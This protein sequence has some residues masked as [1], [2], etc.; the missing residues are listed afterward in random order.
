[1]AYS[2]KLFGIF[3]RLHTATEFEGNGVGLATVARL[4]RR[5][6]GRGLG[7]R[8]S[9]RW[10]QCLLHS[11]KASGSTGGLTMRAKRIL[12]IEDDPDDETLIM[13]ELA[14]NNVA[15]EIAVARD[16]VEA[17]DYLFCSGPYADRDP[18]RNA[19]FD[20]TGSEASQDRR[21]GGF[22]PDT[23]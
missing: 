15:N 18:E 17:L 5:H 13:R 19:D 2:D 14:R 6:G 4:V 10:R 23:V 7:R 8:R 21:S 12:L 22:A 11:W 16:G 3:Q 9:E 20:N 1:M